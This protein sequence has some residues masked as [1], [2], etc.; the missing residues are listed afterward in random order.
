MKPPVNHRIR[1]LVVLVTLGTLLLHAAENTDT[2]SRENVP[3]VEW[4]TFH[5]DA[6]RTGVVPLDMTSPP[7][8]HLWTFDLGSHTWKYCQG[9]SVWSSCAVGADID[10]RMLIFA[11]A[12]DHNVYALDASNGRELWRFTTGCLVGAAPHFSRISGVPMLF[13]ASSDRAFYALD[14]RTGKKIWTMETYPWS[15]TVGESYAGSPVVTTVDGK[16]VLFATMW[17]G[18]RRPLRTIQSGEIF[19]LEP[20][21]GKVIYRREV[22]R[23]ILTSPTVATIRDQTIVYTGSQD[24]NLY[25][26]DARTGDQIWRY[27]SGHR[28]D[29]A[30]AVT[31][32]AGQPVIFFGNAFGMVRCLSAGTGAEIW[33]Y[34]CGHEILSTPAVYTAGNA[35]MLGVGASDRC[36]HGIEAKTGELKWKFETGKYVVSSPAVVGIRGRATVFISSL[37]NGIY[38]IDGETG[39]EIMRFMSGDMLWPYETRG[40][41]IWSSPSIIRPAGGKGILLYPAHDGKLYAFAEGGINSL[42]TEDAVLT[43]WTPDHS[44]SM[45]PGSGP[46]FS[47]GLPLLAFLLILAGLGITFLAKP[48][49]RQ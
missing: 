4:N 13:V 21:S 45:K 48:A 40:I 44:E 22:A 3:A 35:I 23:A 9:A 5:A 46:T 19:A 2:S 15:Y 31:R 30:P 6:A 29:A 18:D 37:D 41:S 16:S 20:D 24:G 32:I 10:G 14:A 12:Y 47:L 27:T 38:A 26:L 17:N 43:D 28:I 1:L 7:F 42:R 34:K 8:A 25:A 49:P 11:G 33:K 36:V 39:C